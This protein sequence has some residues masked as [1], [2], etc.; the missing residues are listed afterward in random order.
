MIWPFYS[1]LCGVLWNGHASLRMEENEEEQHDV[2][3][4]RLGSGLIYFKI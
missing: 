1:Q 2:T 3:I 4:D